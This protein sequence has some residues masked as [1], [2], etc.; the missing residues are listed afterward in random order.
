[1]SMFTDEKIFSEAWND[2]YAVQSDGIDHQ[3]VFLYGVKISKS[4]QDGSIMIENIGS[5]KPNY[6]GL[7]HRQRSAFDSKG[8]RKGVYSVA[9][10]NFVN[11]IDKYTR[12]ISKEND[13]SKIK[14][15]SKSRDLYES[16]L[17]KIKEKNEKSI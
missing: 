11:L 17:N 16:K 6:I 2:S 10:F 9:M 7:N 12:L 14:K 3:S 8:W 1:M 4:K 5:N 13:E 15:Y